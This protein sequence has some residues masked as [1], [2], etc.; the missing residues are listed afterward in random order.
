MI[1]RGGGSGAVRTSAAERRGRLLLRG[2][3][4]CSR[5]GEGRKWGKGRGGR[6][7]AAWEIFSLYFF[8][9]RLTDCWDRAHSFS[10]WPIP[11]P[12]LAH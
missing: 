5:G 6:G 9:D 4:G 12:G 10:F 11:L 2:G 7:V 1:G 8:F 3:D